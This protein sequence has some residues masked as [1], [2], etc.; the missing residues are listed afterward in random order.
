[1]VDETGSM[2]ADCHLRDGVYLTR[3]DIRAV[4]LAKAAIFAGIGCLL[5][6]AGCRAEDVDRVHLAGGFGS[7]MNVASAVR[8]GMIPEAMALRVRPVGNA[9]LDGAAMLLLSPEARRFTEGLAEK[10]Q[11]VPLDGSAVFAE[12]YVEAMTFPEME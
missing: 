12:Q 10:A 1:M 8:I 7:H 9:A 4:Q 3:A 5:A 6:A 2:D 11:H